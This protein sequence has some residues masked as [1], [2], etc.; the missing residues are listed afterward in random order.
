MNNKVELHNK[1]QVNIFYTLLQPKMIYLLKLKLKKQR[2]AII[3]EIQNKL[4]WTQSQ[5]L[6]FYFYIQDIKQFH[7]NV[8]TY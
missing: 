6:S 4:T 8:I 5:C 2:F 3:F 7:R 1:T